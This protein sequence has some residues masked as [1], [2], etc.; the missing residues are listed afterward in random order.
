MT[1][2]LLLAAMLLTIART[3]S[4]S[5]DEPELGVQMDK[6]IKELPKPDLVIPEQFKA[7][8][9]D[10]TS[11]KGITSNQLDQHQKL[12]QGYV[13][14]RNEIAHS[15]TTVDRTNSAGI[16]YS[17]FRALKVAE[18]FALNGSVLH[19]LYFEGLGTGTKPGKKT[20]QL[21][22]ENFGSLEK[23]KKDLLETAGC[24][25]GWAIMCFNIDD[26]KVY[27]Y[28][29]DAHNETV[30]ML[31]LPLLIVDVYEHAYMID[32]GINRAKYLDILWTNINWDVVEKRVEKWVTKFKKLK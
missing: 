6:L 8:S 26:G 27:N 25:R 31:A 16:T 24:S 3:H 9:F 2:Q 17:P 15:L 30:P 28:L 21:I 7:R 23:F 19:E 5:T 1:K 18:T 29:L 4:A 32:F 11:V 22:T 20:L 13:K 14:K 10:L 12:Y